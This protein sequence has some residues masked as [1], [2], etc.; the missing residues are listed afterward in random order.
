V[1][2]LQSFGGGGGGGIPEGKRPLGRPRLR[3]VG[4]ITVGPE[5]TGQDGVELI[6]VV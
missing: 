4:N 3:W 5:E 6:D 2:C 1:R